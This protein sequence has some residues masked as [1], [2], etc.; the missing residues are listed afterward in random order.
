MFYKCNFLELFICRMAAPMDKGGISPFF[1]NN[2]LEKVE[3]SREKKLY[4][5]IY[6]TEY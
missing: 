5:I 2:K 4:S 3:Q 6:A 1:Q